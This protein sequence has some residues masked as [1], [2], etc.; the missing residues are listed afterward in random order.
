MFTT[1]NNTKDSY[2]IVQHLKRKKNSDIE[3]AQMNL[4]DI[5]LSEIRHKQSNT[6]IVLT[7]G[8]QSGKNRDRK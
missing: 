5:L 4:E 8:I 6:V 7:C 2:K 3:T 1:E